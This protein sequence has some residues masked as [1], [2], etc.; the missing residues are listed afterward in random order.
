MRRPHVGERPDQRRHVE[1]IP[2]ALAIG[3]EQHRK[4]TVLGRDG[5][6][7]GRALALLPE[8][9]AHAGAPTGQQ[10]RTG[11]VLAELRREQRRR[12]QLP[13]DKRLHLVGIRQEQPH[14]GRFVHVRKP[15]HEPVIAPQGFDVDAAL[16]ADLR[17]RRHRPRRVDAAAAGREDADAPV[18][19]LV[20]DALDQDRGRVGHGPRGCHLIAEV[21]QEVLRCHG[22]E[23]VVA[24][25]ALDRGGRRQP[26]QRA[27]QLPDREAEFQRSAGAVALPERHLAGFARR[28]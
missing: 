21:L 7:I 27:C 13:D 6:Q 23:V 10:Q 2:E 1:E 14:V 24:C 8:R 9:R 3:F 4:G 18:A 11:G 28:R 15:H 26:E 25:E 5:Q 20:P 16:L 19:E 12:A 22:V 17:R